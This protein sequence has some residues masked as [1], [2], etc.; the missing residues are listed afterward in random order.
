MSPVGATS[1][2]GCSNGWPGVASPRPAA[3][4][5]SSPGL[6]GVTPGLET[7]TAS[8]SAS[9]FAP[10]ACPACEGSPGVAG[11]WPAAAAASSPG[12]NGVTPGLETGTASSTATGCAP[13]ACPACEGSPG[14]AVLGPAAA[15]SAAGAPLPVAPVADPAYE[16]VCRNTYE[17]LHM[18]RSP[19]W[20]QAGSPAPGLATGMAS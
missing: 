14:V 15:A 11:A 3:A 13:S 4:A 2:D 8:S 18:M 12:L 6:K 5:A 19:L 1:S 17:Y 16:Q 20:A 9:G 7:G 10:S